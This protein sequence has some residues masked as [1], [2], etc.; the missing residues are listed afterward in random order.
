M[1]SPVVPTLTMKLHEQPAKTVTVQADKTAVLLTYWD[2]K[3]EVLACRDFP[4]KDNPELAFICVPDTYD[5]VWDI[6]AILDLLDA[7]DEDEAACDVYLHG[8]W[9]GAW[10]S[11]ALPDQISLPSTESVA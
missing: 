8:K 3:G 6:E 11:T 10:Q 9:A 1:N 2:A 5:M 4:V 7:V